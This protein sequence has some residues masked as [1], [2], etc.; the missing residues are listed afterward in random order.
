MNREIEKLLPNAIA[1][2]QAFLMNDK[3]QVQGEYDGY[4]ASLGA[5]IRTSGLI[6]ALVFYTDTSRSD[7]DA[8]RYRLLQAI[9]FCLEYEVNVSI[10][11]HQRLLLDTIIEEVYGKGAT[12]ALQK[13]DRNRSNTMVYTAPSLAKGKDINKTALRKWTHKVVNASIALKLAMR[14]FPHSDDQNPN[15]DAS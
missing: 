8:R 6:P 15:E 14:N 10:Q 12:T 13:P 3:Q 9:A 1:A 5:A 11:A 2:T 4:A 7:G